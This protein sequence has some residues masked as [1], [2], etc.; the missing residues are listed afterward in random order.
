[1]YWGRKFVRRK[2]AEFGPIATLPSPFLDETTN[3]VVFA[4]WGSSPFHIFAPC[5]PVAAKQEKKKKVHRLHVSVSSN[6][7][8][9]LPALIA[10]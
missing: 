8:M 6:S 7:L 10:I 5:T 9:F 4:F 3:C 1:M 2:K